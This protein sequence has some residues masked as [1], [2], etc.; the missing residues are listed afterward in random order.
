MG[1]VGDRGTFVWA[2]YQDAD[3]VSTGPNQFLIRAQGG[4]AINTNTP[5]ETAALTV[6]GN[7]V[8]QS[9]NSLSFGSS[10]RQ[11]LNLW[12]NTYGLPSPGSGAA[13]TAIPGS[14][15]APAAAC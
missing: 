14:I 12:G 7:V 8:V 2:D 3:F 5:E 9:P 15:R 4:V 11:M 1:T 10:T 13:C 6:A